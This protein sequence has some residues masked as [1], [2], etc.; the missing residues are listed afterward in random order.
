MRGEVCASFSH[1]AT[2]IKLCVSYRQDHPMCAMLAHYMPRNIE[3]H[4][5]CFYILRYSKGLKYTASIRDSEEKNSEL[6]IINQQNLVPTNILET[7]FKL[8]A[9]CSFFK[10]GLIAFHF[11]KKMLSFSKCGSF[12][13]CAF[14]FN[15]HSFSM[16][17]HFQ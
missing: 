11:S 1:Q 5:I 14:I 13:K 6:D 9:S 15:S 7:Y 12:S 4:Q 10:K 8:F 2:M 16:G 3:L 17:I